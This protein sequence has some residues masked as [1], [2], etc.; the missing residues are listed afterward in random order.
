VSHTSGGEC[1]F[2]ALSSCPIIKIRLY[3]TLFIMQILDSASLSV[4]LTMESVYCLVIV[5]KNSYMQLL[6]DTLI[7][8]PLPCLY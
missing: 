8:G 4:N 1:T 7:L 6:N 5:F 3:G 2:V